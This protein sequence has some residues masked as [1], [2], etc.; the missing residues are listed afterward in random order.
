MSLYKHD[1]TVTATY[2]KSWDL[3]AAVHA[4]RRPSRRNRAQ[5][6][7][8]NVN[9]CAMK[10]KLARNADLLCLSFF[11]SFSILWFTC[12]FFFYVISVNICSL[13]NDK[14]TSDEKAEKNQVNKTSHRFNEEIDIT[15]GGA[16]SDTPSFPVH[17]QMHINLDY[18]PKIMISIMFAY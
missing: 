5:C 1:I 15:W 7:G 11:L 2:G 18:S 16:P 10:V 9:T 13:N 17:L 12:L 8:Q 14:R 6:Q 4:E 3:R